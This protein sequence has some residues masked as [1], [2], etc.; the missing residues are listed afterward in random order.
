MNKY[1]MLKNNRSKN[2]VNGIIWGVI[3][4]VCAII[5]PFFVRTIIIYKLGVEY[6]GLGS[7]FNS[8][9]SMLSLAELGIGSAIVFS[10]Y[11]PVKDNNTEKLQQYL[12]FYRKCYRTI[13]LIVLLI[14]LALVPLLPYL[15]NNDCPSDV[16]V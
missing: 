7:L 10:M 15:I 8:I 12:N 5:F 2:T 6:T 14:G 1:I 3:Q 4:K 9:L 13:G 11:K 16:N